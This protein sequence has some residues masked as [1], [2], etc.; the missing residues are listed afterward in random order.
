M[1]VSIDHIEKLLRN[2]GIS[3]IKIDMS[4]KTAASTF[5]MDD[6]E[7]K[8]QDYIDLD[9]LEYLKNQHIK[10]ISI[11]VDKDILKKLRKLFPEDYLAAQF[12]DTPDVI[13]EKVNIIKEINKYSRKK[14]E[15]ILMQEV[16]EPGKTAKDGNKVLFKQ[17]AVITENML[18]IIKKRISSSVKLQYSLNENGILVYV[19]NPGKNISMKIDILAVFAKAQIPVYVAETQD[20]AYNLF[21]QKKPKLLLLT[22]LDKAWE[23]QDVFLR[24]IKYDPFL[25][26]INYSSSPSANREK[27]HS[28]I[29]LTYNSGYKAALNQYKESRSDRKGNLE[30]KIRNPIMDKLEYIRHHY[31]R[32]HIIS[33]HY[34]LFKLGLKYNVRTLEIMLEQIKKDNEGH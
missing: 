28:K 6:G 32:S 1:N 24:C 21:L 15:Y 2:E 14:R 23:S 22:F 30:A 3:S 12:E 27:E 18:N 29:M 34:Y 8:Y 26:F 20:Q 9:F 33:M 7:F 16:I 10:K 5:K 4:D 25:K 13:L 31:D 19:N 11:C 17:G